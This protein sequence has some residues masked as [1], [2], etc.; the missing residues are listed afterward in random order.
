MQEYKT[1]Y[2]LNTDVK[3]VINNAIAAS[4]H[5]SRMFVEQYKSSYANIRI[6]LSTTALADGFHCDA[7]VRAG[8]GS[9]IKRVARLRNI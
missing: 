7:N 3:L 1:Y 9:S 6:I 2:L 4:W 8:T 5:R